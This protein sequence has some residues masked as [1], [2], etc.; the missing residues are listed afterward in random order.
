MATYVITGR[1]GSNEPLVSVS[2]SGISQDAPIV[3]EL[4]VVNALRQYLDGVAGVSVVVAQ[5]YEQVITTV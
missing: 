4:D 5:K 1:N 3:D 2:I